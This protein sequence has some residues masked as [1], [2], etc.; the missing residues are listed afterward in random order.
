M[1][2]LK[3]LI[4]AV[5][6]GLM[7]LPLAACGTSTEDPADTPDQTTEAATEAETDFFPSVEKTD[8]QG[9]VFRMVGFNTPAPGTTPS[10]QATSRAASTSSTTPSTR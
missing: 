8:Y 4:A 2:N 5:L 9:E 7:L 6:A 3:R 1:T 10:P